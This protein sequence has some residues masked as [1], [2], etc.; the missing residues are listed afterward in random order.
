[1]PKRLFRLFFG[2]LAFLR[3]VTFSSVKAGSGAVGSGF[4]EGEGGRLIVTKEAV[5]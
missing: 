1:M 3:V 4:V 2:D 5:S